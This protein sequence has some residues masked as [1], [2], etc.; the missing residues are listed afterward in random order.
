MDEAYLK[1]RL[2]ETIRKEMPGAVVYRHEDTFTAGIPDISVTWRGSTTWIEVKFQRRGRKADLTALQSQ[3]IDRFRAAGAAAWVVRYIET[4]DGKQTEV[5]RGADPTA[6][7]PGFDHLQVTC[8]LR[9]EHLKRMPDVARVAEFNAK[10]GMPAPD[11][12]VYDAD[13]LG[14]RIDHIGEELA[15]LEDGENHRD[16]AKVADA[17]VDIVY[18][19]LGAAIN[20]GLPW[21]EL[22]HEVQVAN[23]AKERVE[24]GTH[25]FGIRKPVGWEPPNIRGILGR[26]GY[27]EGGQK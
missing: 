22:F 16:L 11:A 5:R 7:I 4:K 15:E 8:W 23:M 25:K 6:L 9:I 2:V 18:V 14:R 27:K 1:R 24:D 13:V 17:L 3:A 10:F 19:A 21:R 26:Y 12:P 20:L